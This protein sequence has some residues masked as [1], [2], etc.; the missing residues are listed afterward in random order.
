MLILNSSLGLCYIRIA[1][2]LSQ[3]FQTFKAANVFN[4]IFSS[5]DTCAIIGLNIRLIV[6]IKPFPTLKRRGG[7]GRI[8]G[9]TS[10][11]SR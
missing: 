7:V 4:A 5:V 9:K 8:T 10:N 1:P 3:M 11:R 6:T 2:L